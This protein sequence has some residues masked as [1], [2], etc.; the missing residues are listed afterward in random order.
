MIPGL[1]RLFL[2]IGNQ[3]RHS[4]CLWMFSRTGY[5]GGYGYSVPPYGT[6]YRR[7][8]RTTRIR[9]TT[10]FVGLMVKPSG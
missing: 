8:L 7:V 6:S 5:D 9:R 2:G 3:S 1:G 10:R 4:G